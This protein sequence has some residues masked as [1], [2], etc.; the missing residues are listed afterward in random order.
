MTQTHI[1]IKA[2][3]GEGILI[4][5][6]DIGIYTTINYKRSHWGVY[7]LYLPEDFLNSIA[8]KL[9]TENNFPTYWHDSMPNTV[10]ISTAM[11]KAKRDMEGKFFLWIG[12]DLPSSETPYTMEYLKLKLLEFHAMVRYAI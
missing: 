10:N 9:E 2:F 6:E 4:N 8:E 7:Y 1:P 12:N 3:D 11:A 5:N